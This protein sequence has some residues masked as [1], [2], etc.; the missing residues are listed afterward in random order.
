MAPTDTPHVTATVT[1]TTSRRR[2]AEPR[3]LEQIPAWRDLVPVMDPAAVTGA[4]STGLEA[5]LHGKPVLTLGAPFYSGAGVTLDVEAAGDLR[6]AVPALLRYRPEPERLERV[7]HAAMRLGR[8]GAPVLV[9]RSDANA[10]SLAASIEEVAAGELA[11]RAGAGP[12]LH[13]RA[14]LG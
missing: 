2:R 5:L 1:R 7:L 12:E 6:E 11:R 8:P 13:A 9:D 14:G 10:R 3:P 4:P